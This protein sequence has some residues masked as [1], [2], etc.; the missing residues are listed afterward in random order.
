[1]STAPAVSSVEGTS[2]GSDE[3]PFDFYLGS[4]YRAK[5]AKE[6]VQFGDGYIQEGPAALDPLQREWTIVVPHQQEYESLALERWLE[7]RALRPLFWAR[8]PDTGVRHQLSLDEWDWEPRGPLRTYR[9]R[10][11]KVAQ[12]P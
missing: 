2:L 7:G 10:A 9:I 3:F 12:Y 5:I 1:M 4:G 6:S 8:H 11:K